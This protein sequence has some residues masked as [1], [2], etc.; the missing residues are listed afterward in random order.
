MPGHRTLIFLLFVLLA[1]PSSRV[2]A[3]SPQSVND[4]I[5]RGVQFLFDAQKDGN[6]EHAQKPDHSINRTFSY[7]DGQWGMVTA[8][9]TY[10]LLAAGVSSSDEHIKKAVAFLRSAEITGTY[11]L[12][13][14]CQCWARL[15]HT[16]QNNQSLRRDAIQ[17]LNGVLNGSNNKGLFDTFCPPHNRNTLLL[18]ASAFGTLGL[19]C[20]ADTGVAEIPNS[21]W[22]VADKTWRSNQNPD[23]GWGY[24]GLGTA[25]SESA[26][27]AGVTALFLTE[28]YLHQSPGINGNLHDVA[29]EKGLQ[30]ISHIRL[31][32]HTEL[33]WMF[34][35]QRIAAAS[36]LKRFGTMDWYQTMGDLLLRIQAPDG[37]WYDIIDNQ[38][39]PGN[40]VVGTA[41][42]LAILGNGRAPL[43]V[44]KLRY[45]QP[46]KTGGREDGPWNERPR[47]AA[48]VSEWI[49]R[50]R[51]R[52][53]NWQIVDINAPVPDLL[54][55]PL[56]YIAGNKPLVFTDAQ[57]NHLREYLQ[58]GG[59]IVANA[60]GSSK[61]FEASFIKLG[62]K[63]Y[64]SNEFRSL[65]A[66]HA[67]LKLEQFPL[68]AKNLHV[69]GLSNG[70]RELMVLM[71]DDFGRDWQ[72][73][74]HSG[75]KPDF[76]FMADLYSYVS[77]LS[78]VRYKGET[79]LVAPDPNA[80]ITQHL[81]IARIQYAGN[82]DPEP[83]GWTRLTNILHNTQHTDLAVRTAKPSELSPQLFQL[84]HLTATQEFKLSD[85][86]R[87]DLKRYVTGG[88]TLLLDAAGGSDA[89]GV[90]LSIE[91]QAMFGS[92][93]EVL[94]VTDPIY[95]RPL[96]LS[97]FAYRRS[98]LKKGTPN[99]RAIKV[100]N[101]NAV[102]FSS[103]DISG[104]LVGQPID[105]VT[106]YEPE[107]AAGLVTNLLLQK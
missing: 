45:D 62:R 93:G 57:V 17:L 37:S 99:L 76:Q 2:H 40:H 88:G 20:L 4:S 25:S 82:W 3:A 61:E 38:E 26:S 65:P 27:G 7:D 100:N 6:W 83:G 67:L 85:N 64:P 35:I 59:L 33:H 94:P 5:K 103:M 41:Y 91:L 28:K 36:A 102:F 71:R 14:R 56:L 47:D 18:E 72:M 73:N 29:R 74:E 51:E 105:G 106:G 75:H 1:I 80:T 10:G 58:E 79:F 44:N 104:A 95:S 30:F 68:D 52:T 34:L 46:A 89:A 96:D 107:S 98:T 12:C 97:H 8:S 69:Q 70:V 21:Y 87:A 13:M 23:G 9:A 55:A 53:V 32:E 92:T 60:D 77:D 84:A 19:S 63:L 50:N 54:E 90:S 78:N 11:A 22:T 43:V 42:C 48:N 16:D 101:R 49:G 24:G 66:D 86:E 31:D 15:P 81:S 39:Q